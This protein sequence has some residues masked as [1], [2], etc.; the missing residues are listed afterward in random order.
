MVGLLP[1]IA[2]WVL[3]VGGVSRA[4]AGILQQLVRLDYSSDVF[5]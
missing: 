4:D 5:Y 1:G 2:H 3:D